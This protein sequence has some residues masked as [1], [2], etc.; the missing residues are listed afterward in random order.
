MDKGDLYSVLKRR[1]V[2]ADPNLRY[3]QSTSYLIHSF[4]ILGGG[5]TNVTS[6]CFF[7]FKTNAVIGLSMLDCMIVYIWR[8]GRQYYILGVCMCGQVEAVHIQ[9]CGWIFLIC[10]LSGFFPLIGG[11]ISTLAFSRFFS[12]P[13]SHATLLILILKLNTHTVLLNSL[14][15]KSRFCYN[16]SFLIIQS[17]NLIR[18]YTSYTQIY[19]LYANIHLLRKYTSYTQIYI[20]S[21]LYPESQSNFSLSHNF[22]YIF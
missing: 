6:M 2:N 12:S 17:Y 18:K 15:S 1:I 8:I 3:Y 4:F 16:V 9:T 19:I 20:F 13:G 22:I 5:G 21:H 7:V 11:F 14:C 10:G